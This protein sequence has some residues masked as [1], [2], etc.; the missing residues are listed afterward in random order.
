LVP[1]QTHLDQTDLQ[2]LEDA[3]DALETVHDDGHGSL[4]VRRCLCGEAA[5]WRR[6]REVVKRIRADLGKPERLLWSV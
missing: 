4:P 2:W 3:L 5:S 6:A 1:Q